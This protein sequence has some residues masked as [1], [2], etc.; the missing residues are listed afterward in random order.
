[1]QKGENFQDQLKD[2][3]GQ[4]NFNTQDLTAMPTR[5]NPEVKDFSKRAKRIEIYEQSEAICMEKFPGIQVPNF[6]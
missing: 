4:L 1:M 2:I 3:A 5:K 6:L